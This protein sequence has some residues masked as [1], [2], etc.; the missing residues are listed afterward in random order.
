MFKSNI[1]AKWSSTSTE[2]QGY[3]NNKVKRS[4]RR[5]KGNMVYGHSSHL[6]IVCRV[7]IYIINVFLYLRGSPLY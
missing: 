2:Y 1:Y 5:K 4:V 7:I 3:K 6:T